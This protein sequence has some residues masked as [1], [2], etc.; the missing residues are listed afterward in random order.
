MKRLLSYLCLITG[1]SCNLT[2]EIKEVS[3]CELLRQPKTS[4]GVL[5]RTT[6]TLRG[7]Y[8]GNS[9][10]G[11]PCGKGFVLAPLPAAELRALNLDS[12]DVA[13]YDD[14]MRLLQ[15]PPGELTRL[16]AKVIMEGTLFVVPGKGIRLR[17][18]RVVNLDLGQAAPKN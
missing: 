1:V 10:E 6:G 5:M 3:L 14:F 17:V 15:R 4:L 8:H 18:E 9:L 2:G 7:G 16:R 11:E 13:R 12:Q